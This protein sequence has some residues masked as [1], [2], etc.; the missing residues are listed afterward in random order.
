MHGNCQKLSEFSMKR[1][2]MKS[3]AYDLQND[4]VHHLSLPRELNESNHSNNTLLIAVLSCQFLLEALMSCELV[5]AA[6]LFPTT[7][8]NRV[9]WEWKKNMDVCWRHI[10]LS[11]RSSLLLHPNPNDEWGRG[12]RQCMPANVGV[13]AS[14][15]SLPL[16]SMKYC[17]TQRRILVC[18]EDPRT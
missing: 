1:I 9:V 4:S 15:S 7:I 16:V 14:A 13:L 8:I 10:R 11:R 12:R 6:R 5:V 2:E 18:A 17:C 3:K